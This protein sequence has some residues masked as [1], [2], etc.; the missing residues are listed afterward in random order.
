MENVASTASIRQSSR[1]RRITAVICMA[2]PTASISRPKEMDGEAHGPR[3]SR[4]PGSSNRAGHHA[5]N[6]E[7]EVRPLVPELVRGEQGVR[8]AESCR[9][10]MGTRILCGG[11]HPRRRR[12]SP[13]QPHIP[14]GECSNEESARLTNER[15]LVRA[16]PRPFCLLL[17]IT[18]LRQSPPRRV[19]A[20]VGGTGT[21]PASTAT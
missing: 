20:A 6:V 2:L 9:P 11:A 17:A 8:R 16:Q 18:F 3:H 15:L 13:P 4:S 12:A 7:I 14:A 1:T 21:A 10:Q 19:S 5:L